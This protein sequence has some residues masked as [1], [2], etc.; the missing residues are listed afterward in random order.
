MTD[1]PVF[2]HDERR[3]AQDVV[4]HLIDL[5]HRHIAMI[6]GPDGHIAASARCDGFRDA[7]NSAGL[8]N[9]PLSIELGDYTMRSG[10]EAAQRL[11]SQSEKPT[12]IFAANDDMAV[13]ALTAAP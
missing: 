3:A 5:G 2:R 7:M 13:G 6:A 12:A 11:F 1:S 4:N 9:E 8:G 10:L